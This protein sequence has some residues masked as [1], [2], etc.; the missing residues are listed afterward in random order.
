MIQEVTSFAI[1][2]QG[3]HIERHHPYKAKG[4]AEDTCFVF[5]GFMDYPFIPHY[6]ATEKPG[7]ALYRLAG[8]RYPELHRQRR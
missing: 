6:P 4:R 3:Q 5:E 2:F 7:Y 8:L 1:P